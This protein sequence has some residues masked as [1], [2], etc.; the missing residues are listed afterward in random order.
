ME[1]SFQPLETLMD[2]GIAANDIQKL[3]AAGF[4]TVQSVRDHHHHDVR[5][6]SGRTVMDMRSN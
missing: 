4:H 5:T 3:Q 2:H 6:K 1:I